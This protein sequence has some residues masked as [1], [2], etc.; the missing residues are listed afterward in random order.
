VEA[1]ESKK[2][3]KLPLL[4]TANYRLDFTHPHMFRKYSIIIAIITL[5]GYALFIPI[6]NKA[7][8][9]VGSWQKGVTIEPRW[10]TDF[11][12]A[13]F[14]QSVQNAAAIHANYITL[15][16]PLY[17]SN[18]YATDV[19]A[20]FNTPTDQ[21]LT[22]AI[23]YVH[24]LGLHV[25]VKPHLDSY[26]GQWRANINPG[27]RTGWFNNYG[28]KIKHYAQIAGNAGA[29]EFSVGA[30]LISMST[31]TSNG[32]N[33]ANWNALI[34]SVRGIYSGLLTYSANWGGGWFGDEKN[35]ID[36]W[37]SLDSIGISAYFNLYNSSNT[38]IQGLKNSWDNYNNSDITPLHNKYGKPVLFTE[39]GYRSVTNAHLEPWNSGVGGAYDPTEQS[40]DFSA[41]FDYWQSQPFMVGIHIWNWNSDPTY[42]GQGN[43]DYTPQ[44]KP[45]TAVIS[46]WF[47]G[48]STTPPPPPPTTVQCTSPTT[49]SF[50][51]C[52]FNDKN[53]TTSVLSRSDS[54]INFDWG[55]GS[56]DPKVPVD[57]FSARWEG[58]FNFN[59]GTYNFI[60]TSDDGARLFIDNQLVLN[61]WTDQP[62]TTYTVS[63]T[64][65]AGAHA[66]KMEYYEN[67]GNAVAKLSWNQGTNTPPPP[68]QGTSCPKPSLNAFTGCYFSNQDLTN[69]AVIQTDSSI[70]FD[71]GSGSPDPKIPSDHFS[72]RWEG[73]FNFAG[74]SY[75]FNATGDD[76]I[77]VYIDGNPIINQW[78]DQPA[79]TYSS[80]QNISAGTH[81]VK[82]EYYEN[83]GN[84]V[85]KVNWNLTT[86]T[87]PPPPPPGG[88]TT[89]TYVNGYPTVNGNYIDCNGNIDNDMGHHTT[90][91]GDTDPAH[92]VGQNCPAGSYVATH[93]GP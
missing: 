41:L 84:S 16:V 62:T 56:P 53:L 68:P 28:T 52:Y 64:M 14:K 48:S 24:S 3:I 9:S 5:L 87:T 59:A 74:G 55:A 27:D 23:N 66:I 45:A 92:H 44:N 30:E 69:L 65:T 15:I 77:R 39:V 11:S 22:D 60:M 34:A 67:G 10:N 40:T 31:Y 71:W 91:S 42:G 1:P 12:S 46:Q 38:D 75:V 79:T 7:F 13:S 47:A 33:S 26:D 6:P 61:K 72:V 29:E 57:N 43:T 73:D 89:I 19:Q 36:F 90:S 35:H 82:V 54:Q 58:N 51:G 81:R 18:I 17:Q 49:G 83:G 86:T 80:T 50:S 32:T 4:D 20:G 25:L 78:K 93:S 76:G 21:S 88:G 70:N 63:Q 85:A 37:G 8:A 2:N